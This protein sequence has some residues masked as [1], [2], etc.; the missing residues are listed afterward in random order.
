MQPT[1]HNML[2]IGITGGIGSG[3]TLVCQIFAQLGVPVYNADDAAKQLV[4]NNAQLKAEI[5]EAFG[6]DAFINGQYNR[7]YIASI[8]FS[9]PQRLNQLNA[10]IHP[11]VFA[12]WQAFVA[13]HQAFPYVIKE[14]AIMLET[15][16]RYTVD[17]IVLVYAPLEL[18]LARLQNRDGFNLD[19]TLKRIS[20]QMSEE[21]KLKLCHY[22]IHNDGEQ[23][24]IEQIMDLHSQFIAISK[25]S[26]TI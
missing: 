21:D 14:A 12:D 19:D 8:V 5:T 13:Q 26:N 23:A 16:S 11:Y 10:I 9:D 4:Q 25:H 20:N 3:K 1:R 7:G 17:K 24:L 6:P 2:K 18:R 22:V 15:D